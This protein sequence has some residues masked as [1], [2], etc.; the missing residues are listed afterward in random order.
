[1]SQEPIE[2]K[3]K[4][5][6]INSKLERLNVV[7]AEQAKLKKEAEKLTSSIKEMIAKRAKLDEATGAYKIEADT[8]DCTATVTQHEVRRFDTSGF[9]AKHPTLADE[10]TNSSFQ[11]KLTF[12][13][14]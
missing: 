11:Q 14:V 7:K 4:N 5:K 10:F 8:G 2:I 13:K 3:I 9:R 1:M 6:D 12:K